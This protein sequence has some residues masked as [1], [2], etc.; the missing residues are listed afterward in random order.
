MDTGNNQL[1][2]LLRLVGPWHNDFCGGSEK[3]V[4]LPVESAELL[5]MPGVSKLVATSDL[6]SPIM[7]VETVNKELEKPVVHSCHCWETKQC[8]I[9]RLVLCRCGRNGQGMALSLSLVHEYSHKRC[10]LYLTYG[11]EYF[12]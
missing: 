10:H 11:Y 5:G 12:L 1:E 3:A 2:M 9:V 6:I 8:C 4:A 7:G